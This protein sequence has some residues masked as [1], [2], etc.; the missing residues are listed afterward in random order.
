MH[1]LGN[2]FIVLNAIEQPFDWQK[3]DIVRLADRHSGIGF[4]QLLIV[5]RSTKADFHY[6]IYNG[7]G[8]EVEHCG[9]G[10]RCLGKYLQDNQLFDYHRPVLVSTKN[11][12][13]QIQ[14]CSETEY[15]V[16]MGQPDFSPLSAV[17]TDSLYQEIEFEG[18]VYQF[19]I[20]SL[21]NPHA[22]MVCESVETAPVAALGAYLQA[23]ALFPEQVNVGFMQVISRRQI[24]LRVYER[25]AGETQA[26]GTGACAAMAIGRTRGLLDNTVDVH[27]KRGKLC[28]DWDG[29]TPLCMTGEAHTV[30]YG[31]LA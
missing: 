26:C 20:V 19:G 9:N 14:R 10:A 4:D 21:G 12:L 3:S 15:A 16:D 25:G 8:T 22:V 28:I 27:L 13:I 31:K 30:Y 6:R 24:Q 17:Q 23:H 7:D 2:D 29:H 1:A 5:E 11:R 18:K